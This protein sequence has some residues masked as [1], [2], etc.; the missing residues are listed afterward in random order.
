MSV[1]VLMGSCSGFTPSYIEATDTYAQTCVVTATST[2]L[3]TVM[4]DLGTYSGFSELTVPLTLDG[5]DVS[6]YV[7]FAPLIQ[8]NFK[9]SDITTTTVPSTTSKTAATAGSTG[10]S[11]PS[12]T[13]GSTTSMAAGAT[14]ASSQS[15]S[16]STQSIPSSGSSSGS[17]SGPSQSG[18][19]T[20]AKIGI[21]V[22]VGVG[23]LI[24]VALAILLLLRRRRNKPAQVGAAPTAAGAAKGKPET[25]PLQA[26]LGSEDVKEMAQTPFRRGMG[27]MTRRLPG[28]GAVY[29]LPAEATPR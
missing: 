29:E 16:S 15:S 18:L 11:L 3:E 2:T 23:G 28:N 25:N 5:N 26:E 1:C 10:Q 6:S 4:C 8:L 14:T 17:S 22:G 27:S 9:S 20:G 21:G 24:L 13:T 12:S 7:V 19:S